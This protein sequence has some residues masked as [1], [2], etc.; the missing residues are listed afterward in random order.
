MRSYQNVIL[1]ASFHHPEF[2]PVKLMWATISNE[3][4]A[5]TSLSNCIMPR[6]Y[7]KKRSVRR[8]I[9]KIREKVG[10]VDNGFLESEKVSNTHTEPLTINLIDGSVRDYRC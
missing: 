1:R 6:G 9:K 4:A 5:K 3:V 8:Y 10:V 2:N 7:P